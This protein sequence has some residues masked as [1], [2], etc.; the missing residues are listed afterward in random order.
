MQGERVSGR[1]GGSVSDGSAGCRVEW[2]FRVARGLRVPPDVQSSAW[3]AAEISD[4]YPIPP[5][6]AGHPKSSLPQIPAFP[7]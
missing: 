1:T 7:K 5:L 6:Q 4:T 3:S 2:V